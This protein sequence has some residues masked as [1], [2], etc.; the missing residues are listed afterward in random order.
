MHGEPNLKRKVKSKLKTPVAIT[1]PLPLYTSYGY[2]WDE[3]KDFMSQRERDAF[4]LWMRGQ[5]VGILDVT[6]EHVYYRGDVERFLNS[7]RNG[8][9]P[10]FWD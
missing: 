5:T 2:I 7:V 8:R 4:N 10:S 6:N 1:L 3:I 9:Q